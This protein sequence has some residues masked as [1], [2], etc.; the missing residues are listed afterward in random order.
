MISM[1]EKIKPY[2]QKLRIGALW[3]A[4]KLN[5]I[6]T[7]VLLSFVYIVVIG[8]MSLIVRLLRKDFLQ[9]KDRAKQTTYWQKRISSEQ[10][11]ERQKHQF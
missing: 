11:L 8:F 5:W 1:N 7:S 4:Q 3:F 9:K 6:Y 2:L 10:T